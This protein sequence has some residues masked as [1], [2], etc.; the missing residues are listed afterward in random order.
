MV[1]PLDWTLNVDS[2][3]PF[4]QI[5]ATDLKHSF[6]AK[7]YNC[8]PASRRGQGIEEDKRL[9][10][11]KNGVARDEGIADCCLLGSRNGYDKSIAINL[12]RGVDARTKEPRAKEARD[13]GS[14]WR[15]RRRRRAI[16]ESRL[17]LLLFSAVSEEISAEF[18]WTSNT[19][20]GHRWVVVIPIVWEPCVWLRP[21][22]VVSFAGEG[23]RD[24]GDG[25]FVEENESPG[26][27]GRIS[28]LSSLL[29][30]CFPMHARLC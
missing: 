21:V 5:R 28:Q 16:T 14:C 26:V 17:E 9:R 7:W 10:P 23:E 3:F 27:R 15:R 18:S 6:R 4:C 2:A 24:R 13:R 20:N 25:R 1:G 22:R 8:L 19:V 12:R 11:E 30:H 29:S